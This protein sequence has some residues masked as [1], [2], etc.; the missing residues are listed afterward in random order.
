MTATAYS[1]VDSRKVHANIITLP[2][3][4]HHIA[5]QASHLQ[6]LHLLALSYDQSQIGYH[7]CDQF[8]PLNFAISKQ[9]PDWIF[10][11]CFQEEIHKDG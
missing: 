3:S 11:Y 8:F 5:F 10:F 1:N 6:V 2:S 9:L 7:K 4:D